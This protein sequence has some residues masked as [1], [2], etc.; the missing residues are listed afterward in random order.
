MG[1]R[2]LLGVAH[3]PKPT[4]EHAEDT[5][6]LLWLTYRS[7][8]PR[9]EP[10]AFTDDSGWGCMLRSA[11]M[12]M[13]QGLQRHLLGRHW[14]PSSDPLVRRRHPEYLRILALLRDEPGVASLFSIHNMCQVGMRYDKLPGEWYGP[15]TAALVLRDLS[16]L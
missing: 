10:Y 13:A 2:W 6:A 1:E 9:L 15:N 16:R 7:G 4:K 12:V 5:Q 3:P 8:F 11:Q 14:R